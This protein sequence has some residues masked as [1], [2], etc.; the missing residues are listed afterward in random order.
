MSGHV[1]GECTV[2]TF[3]SIWPCAVDSTL[4]SCYLLTDLR[5]N[6]QYV[7]VV[8]DVVHFPPQGWTSGSAARRRRCQPTCTSWRTTSWWYAST[9]WALSRAR[10]SAFTSPSPGGHVSFPRR[11]AGQSFTKDS[12]HFHFPF[13]VVCLELS[14]HFKQE[15]YKLLIFFM[16]YTM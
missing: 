6:Q 11:A 1:G 5:T 2:C 10:D 12:I 7:P 15:R 3:V 9:L 16:T 8:A 13:C 4:K 14:S